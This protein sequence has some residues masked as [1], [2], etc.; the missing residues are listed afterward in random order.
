MGKLALIVLLVMIAASLA[1]AVY[2]IT[3]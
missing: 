2:V 3:L 1:L